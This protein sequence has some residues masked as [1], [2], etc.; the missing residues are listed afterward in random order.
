MAHI[1]TSNNVRY[2]VESV[3]INNTGCQK[4]RGF[5]HSATLGPIAP[6]LLEI[7]FG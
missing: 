7:E 4:E 3:A 2:Y 1:T 6:R 5:P